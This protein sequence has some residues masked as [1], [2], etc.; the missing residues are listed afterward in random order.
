[1]ND[2]GERQTSAVPNRQPLNDILLIE[3]SVALSTLLQHRLERETSARVFHSASLEDAQR[4]LERQKFTLALTGLNLP[5]APQGE[6]LGLLGR[7]QVPTIVFTA[8]FDPDMST[9]YAERKIID[10]IVKNGDRTV[11][12]VIGTVN[13]ILANGQFSVLVVDDARTARSGLVEIL[14]RQNFR[15]LEA[16]SGRQALDILAEEP[17]VEL[18][19]TDYHMAD[20]DGHELTRRI[21]E[22]RPSDELRIIGVSSSS[23][24][25]LSANFLKA[26][27]SD[28]IYR[29]FVPEE[30][31]CRIDNTVETL[32][33]IKRLRYLAE[34]DYL[35]GLANR[36]YF[37]E[38]FPPQKPAPPT[39]AVAILDID[40]FKSINDTHGHEAGDHVLQALAAILIEMTA[41]GRHL[42]ARLG[43]E[44]FAIYIKDCNAFQ[45]HSLCERI[46]LH[47]EKTAIPVNGKTI[48]ITISIGVVEMEEGETFGNQLN[49]ADQLL[50]MAKMNGRN[51]V[52]SNLTLQEALLPQD[53]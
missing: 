19:I 7:H 17:S 26:G 45:A 48:A 38:R 12:T 15:V 2:G 3:D 29:P 39:D 43:G 8:T 30:L 37:F 16:H 9:R 18:V 13:R 51:R 42:P 33:Q 40:H 49:A 25:R 24:R 10:Y 31:Q 46:R 50:Y 28:F 1:M 32:T 14:E 20:M 27:A 23:D 21:R 36:R 44:E 6:V 11:D 22:T 5:D 52:Y 53:N 47:V 4:Q 34:R 35:T 41:E